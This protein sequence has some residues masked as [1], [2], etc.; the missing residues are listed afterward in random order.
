M[1]RVVLNMDCLRLGFDIFILV[2]GCG[3]VGFLFGFLIFFL[4]GNLN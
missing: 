1:F 2:Y 4:C 3:V